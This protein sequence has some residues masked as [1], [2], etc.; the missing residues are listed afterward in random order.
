MTPITDLS[1][2]KIPRDSAEADGVGSTCRLRSPQTPESSQIR[3]L[4]DGASAL[5]V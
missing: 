4:A 5:I 1:V 3:G 2:R